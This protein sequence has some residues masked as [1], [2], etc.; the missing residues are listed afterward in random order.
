MTT[1]VGEVVP[2]PEVLPVPTLLLF[3]LLFALDL[4]VY[5]QDHG[6]CLGT[7][8]LNDEHE[9]AEDEEGGGVGLEEVVK[10]THCVCQ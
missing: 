3:P 1:I 8:Y 7:G 4:H 5:V 6:L 9:E 10:D 2:F